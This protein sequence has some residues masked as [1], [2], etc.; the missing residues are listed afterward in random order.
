MNSPMKGSGENDDN[1]SSCKKK[2]EIKFSDIEKIDINTETNTLTIE[3]SEKPKEYKEHNPQ[4]KK[5]YSV[6]QRECSR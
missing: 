2:F 6:D 4:P 3:S 5:K 1:K